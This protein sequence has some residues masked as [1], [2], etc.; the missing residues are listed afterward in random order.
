[1]QTPFLLDCK[2]IHGNVAS[3]EVT[4]SA[5]LTVILLRLF[6]EDQLCLSMT[7]NVEQYVQQVVHFLQQQE[8]VFVAERTLWL[9]LS[10]GEY[11]QVTFLEENFTR[12]VWHYLTSEEVRLLLEEK[13]TINTLH[14]KRTS[15]VEGKLEGESTT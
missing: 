8:E 7:N 6:P 2:D 12:P 10:S 1:M 14:E 5:R 3:V 13:E 11:N 9:Q 4:C 15:I